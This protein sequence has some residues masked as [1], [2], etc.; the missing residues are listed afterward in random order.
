MKRTKQM[1]WL[2]FGLSVTTFLTLTACGGGGGGGA[3]P[4]PTATAASVV[5]GGRAGSTTQ[6]SSLVA[7][8]ARAAGAMKAAAGDLDPAL[9]NA[10]VTL[11]VI[12]ADGTSTKYYTVTDENGA[13]S[14]EADIIV[15]D[16][17]TVTFEK[18]GFTTF[19]KTLDT[20]G[21]AANEKRKF[22]VNGQAAQTGIIV[23]TKSGD[24]FKA[25]GGTGPGFRFGLMRGGN[26]VHRAFASSSDVRRAATYDGSKPELDISIP[27]SWAPDA[28]AIS[29]KLAAF[30]P[31]LPADR[32]MFPG[33]FVG[34]GGKIAGVAASK[35][36]VDQ[37]AYQLESVS[38][39]S[40]DVTPN[41]GSQLVTAA[42]AS[43]AGV[44][45]AL[46]PGNA[47]IYKYIPKDGCTAIQKYKDRD[48]VTAGVQVPLYTYK[49]STGKWGYL[50]EGTLAVYTS[51]SGE[52]DVAVVA[53][54]ATNLANLACDSTDY[55]F[56][57]NTAEWTT[58]WNLDYPILLAAPKT[59]TLCGTVVDQNT[60]AVPNA[61]V[62]ADGYVG[63]LVN[64]IIE[65]ANSY[66]YAYA[67]ANG[68][69]QI[70]ILTGTG[71]ELNKFDFAAY[72]YSNYP[73]AS[74]KDTDGSFPALPA[75]PVT[76]GC[77]E[78]GNVV[79]PSLTTGTIKGTLKEDATP[80]TALAGQW[81]W[82]ESA[83]SNNYFY[84]WAQTDEDGTFAMKAPLGS[85]PKGANLN[86]WI[87]GKS[88][89]VKI[90][91]IAAGFE[92]LD[93]GSIVTMEEIK[94][95]NSPPVVSTWISPNPAKAGK[96]VTLSAWA[97][98]PEGDYPLT[99]QWKIDGT[100]LSTLSEAGW[101]PDSEGNKVVEIIVTDSKN[102]STTITQTLPV[103]S[104]SNALPVI[105]YTWVA[106]A[107]SCGGA[108]TIYAYSYDPDGEP[109]TYTWS[110]I[111]GEI[112]G[113]YDA[114]GGF[115]PSIA[116]VGNVTLTVSDGIGS[117]IQTVAIPE[118]TQ[119]E[120]TDAGP[121]PLAPIVNTTVGLN[122]NAFSTNPLTYQWTIT[123]PDNSPVLFSGTDAWIDFT[124]DQ[125]G[126]YA[127]DLTVS[128][129]CSSETRQFDVTVKLA[130]SIDVTVQ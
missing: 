37:T 99:Y 120:I 106:P 86:V 51:A 34:I 21:T 29:A 101:T 88:Y 33:E 3:A 66:H 76:T 26:G 114:N 36:A 125:V 25:G 1:R 19:A 58:W 102:K 107:T 57:I 10:K 70:E 8:S 127:I 49:S 44:A 28:T 46:V 78:I 85:D 130:T 90:D 93:D 110:N 59:V 40:A 121:F 97:W 12:K 53:N 115:I 50:G 11:E 62:V 30:D 61:Y 24:V 15:G 35:A 94:Q 113:G 69:F 52:Y 89:P 43:A 60:N 116:P 23:S 65:R 100:N 18:E 87:L 6:L 95:P 67:G 56:A 75:S 82:V 103:A 22:V 109:L 31:S 14:L 72:D 20:T 91:G 83:D 54:A 45:R 38:F 79:I 63:V 68:K 119:F 74:S 98:D 48:S 55:Y 104:A 4:A 5:V 13:Y 96:P 92:A 80:P 77:N 126:V 7:S 17:V 84:N 118:S 73:Y 117:V 81:V 128:D 42:K 32:A 105:Y 9:A 71:K 27:G 112:S 111:G 41:D 122:A 124:P 16:V 2:W 129:G 47:L 39:F 108:P 123:A 64:N